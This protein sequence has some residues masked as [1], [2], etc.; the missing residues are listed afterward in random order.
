MEL[1]AFVSDMG[2]T[3]WAAIQER[4]SEIDYDFWGWAELRWDRAQAI[5]G[6]PR[7]GRLLAQVSDKR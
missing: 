3:L 2:W 5:M 4:I 6:S 1:H 7:F